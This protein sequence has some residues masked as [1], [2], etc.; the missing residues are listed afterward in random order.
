MRHLTVAGYTRAEL[1]AIIEGLNGEEVDAVLALRG[2]PP[3]GPT[4]PWRP[5][6]GGLDYA[7]QLVRLVSDAGHDAGVAAFPEGHPA[8]KDLDQDLAVLRLK[9]EAG[10]AFAITQMVF[11]VEPYR[12]FVARVQA[13]GIQLPIVP[14]IMPVTAAAQLARLE[15]FAGAP[16]PAGLVGRLADAGAEVT[17]QREVGIEW[18]AEL[19]DGLLAAGAPGIHFYTLN[20][21]GSSLEV[22]R[23]IGLRGRRLG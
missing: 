5:Q 21:T 2:D 13:G 11:G 19:A 20:R 17:A 8:S 1:V 10:A 18:A 7:A 14:G 16:L 4:V 12:R 22:C 6:S 23:R 3:G 15:V 9:E